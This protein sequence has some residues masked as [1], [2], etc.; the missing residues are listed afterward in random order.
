MMCYLEYTSLLCAQGTR[1]KIVIRGAGGAAKGA[2]VQGALRGAWTPGVRWGVT[3]AALAVLCATV[4]GAAPVPVHGRLLSW[5]F[6]EPPAW[7]LAL[8]GLMYAQ[9]TECRCKTGNFGISCACRPG[10]DVAARVPAAVAA[11]QG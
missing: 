4:W 11:V 3:A 5:T 6:P 1:S 10:A 9:P 2:I 8:G 7:V